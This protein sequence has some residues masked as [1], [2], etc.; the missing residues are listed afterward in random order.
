M[1]KGALTSVVAVG[2]VMVLVVP[3]YPF[4]CGSNIVSIGDAK[5]KVL[6]ECGPPTFKERVGVKEETYG[7]EARGKKHAKK[8]KAKNVE[9][10]TYN[11]GESDFIYILTFEG[12]KLTK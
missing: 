6:L 11:C 9:Q 1:V 10:W 4:R 2:L 12:G 5:A 8:K 7:G 3:G